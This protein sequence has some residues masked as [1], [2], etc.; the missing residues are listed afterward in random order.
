MHRDVGPCGA[1]AKDTVPAPIE[2]IERHLDMLDIGIRERR[3]GL[4]RGLHRNTQ[5]ADDTS[6]AIS[7]QALPNHPTPQRAL[8]GTVQENAVEM[9]A[10]ERLTGGGDAGLD[11]GA[12]FVGGAAIGNFAERAEFG[13]DPDGAI[14]QSVP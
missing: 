2:K 11:G 8:R 7:Q 13:D 3:F 5:T 6:A 10:A 9:I 1:Q 12:N 4:I 14:R